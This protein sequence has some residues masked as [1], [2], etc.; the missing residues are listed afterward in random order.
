MKRERKIEREK[1][2]EEDKKS[3]REITRRPLMVRDNVFRN[4]NRSHLIDSV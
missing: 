3:D 2:K 1:Y 4:M